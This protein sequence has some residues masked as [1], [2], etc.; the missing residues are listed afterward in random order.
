ME[1]LNELNEKYTN[2]RIIA[3]RII[4]T[5]DKSDLLDLSYDELLCLAKSIVGEID[6]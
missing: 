5:I 2:N 6:K 3:Y 4:D 1:Q